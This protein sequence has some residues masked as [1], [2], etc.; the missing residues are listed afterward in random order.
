MKVTIDIDCTPEEAR[1]FLGLPD[2]APLQQ[3]MM[4]QI[5]KRIEDNMGQMDIENVMQN[6]APAAMQGMGQM[7]KVFW[8]HIQAMAAGGPQ[9]RPGHSGK[10]QD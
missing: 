10:D 3:S 9:S 7:Q 4:E 8:E 5:Q 1:Q 6:W 2:V